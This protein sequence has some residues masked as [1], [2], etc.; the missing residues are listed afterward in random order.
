MDA[1]VVVL[2]VGLAVG[3]WVALISA[4]VSAL[5]VEPMVW[6]VARR[7]KGINVVLI[8]CTGGIGGIYYWLR[9]RPQLKVADGRYRTTPGRTPTAAELRAIAAADRFAR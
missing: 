6:R 7:R 4:L 2:W 9:I 8:L 3:L 1:L 5:R